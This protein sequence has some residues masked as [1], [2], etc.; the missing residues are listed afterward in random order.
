MDYTENR[1]Q[2]HSRGPGE[3]ELQWWGQHLEDK[4]KRCCVERGAVHGLQDEAE[5]ALELQRGKRGQYGRVNTTLIAHSSQT[6][7]TRNALQQQLSK[8]LKEMCETERSIAQLEAALKERQ[9][10]LRMEQRRLRERAPRDPEWSSAASR[11][12]LGTL[13][14]CATL[15]C[16]RTV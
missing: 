10:Q 15:V 9:I 14:T 11:H 2:R 4:L 13:Q 3:L 6:T 7:Y 5:R 12:T 8:T 1:L 16:N